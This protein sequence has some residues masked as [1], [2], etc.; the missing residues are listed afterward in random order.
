[1]KKIAI[2]IILILV[3]MLCL[4]FVGCSENGYVTQHADAGGY[5][6]LEYKVP[7]DLIR[8]YVEC[9]YVDSVQSKWSVEYLLINGVKTDDYDIILKGS[10]VSIVINNYN[11]PPDYIKIKVIKLGEKISPPEY[12][13]IIFNV[14]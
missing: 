9:V 11:P 3:L 2:I 8:F 10:K 12:R 4:S 6:I 7:F 14:N 1:M 5:L 13:E